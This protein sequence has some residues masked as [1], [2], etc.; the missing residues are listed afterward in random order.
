MHMR[1]QRER[2]ATLEEQDCWLAVRVGSKLQKGSGSQGAYREWIYQRESNLLMDAMAL[3]KVN[4]DLL[5]HDDAC[6]FQKHIQGHKALKHAFRKVRYYLIDEFH[7]PN[8]KCQKRD[9]KESRNKTS[10]ECTHQYGRSV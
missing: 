5:I 7:R 4:P 10:E 6:H 9:L 3:P 8:H 2:K 1:Q